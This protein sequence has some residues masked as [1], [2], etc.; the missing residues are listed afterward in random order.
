MALPDISRSMLNNSLVLGL[1]AV[2]TVGLVAITQFG[3]AERIA[4]ARIR[5]AVDI[6]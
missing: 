5:K 4:A 6:A 2:L 1:F 3:T